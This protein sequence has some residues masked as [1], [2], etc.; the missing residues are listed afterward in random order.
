MAEGYPF[1]VFIR[2]VAGIVVEE[3]QPERIVTLLTPLLQQ[4]LASPAGMPTFRPDGDSA[5]IRHHLLHEEGDGSFFII[6]STLQ[7]GVSTGPHL[8]GDWAL[9]GVLS[10]RRQETGYRRADEGTDLTCAELV[11]SDRVL[12]SPGEVWRMLPQECHAGANPEQTPLISLHLLAGTPERHPY[13]RYNAE[14]RTLHRAH[15]PLARALH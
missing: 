7:P 9:G 12:K 15:L 11:E 5:G 3:Q 8:H 13:Y 10:G 14:S 2:D 4:F 1:R 6:A